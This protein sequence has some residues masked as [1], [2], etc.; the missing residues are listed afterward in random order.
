MESLSLTPEWQRDEA[1]RTDISSRPRSTVLENRVVQGRVTRPSGGD[2]P[3]PGWQNR[4]WASDRASASRSPSNQQDQQKGL[5]DNNNFPTLGPDP[6]RRPPAE[7]ETPSSTP[8]S[9]P[10]KISGAWTSRSLEVTTVV[11]PVVTQV[12][13][14]PNNDRRDLDRMRALVPT[15]PKP[16]GSQKVRKNLKKPVPNEPK[17][18]TAKSTNDSASLPSSTSAKFKSPAPLHKPVTLSRRGSAETVSTSFA[19]L[20]LPSAST[21]PTS[22]TLGS[23]LSH[24][25]SSDDESGS[26]LLSRSSSLTSEEE[27]DFL[28]KLGWTSDGEEGDSEKGLLTADEISSFIAKVQDHQ[29]RSV[30]AQPSPFV[31]AQDDTDSSD[32]DEDY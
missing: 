10:A 32:S 28:R 22:P 31:L 8:P 29:R 4:R 30:P 20:A 5:F 23:E 7:E 19:S 16:I 12:K 11:V 25:P 21:A 15:V 13:Q 24:R 17:Y 14:T 3:S 6:D 18:F 27:K 9:A 2:D 1:A 26:P